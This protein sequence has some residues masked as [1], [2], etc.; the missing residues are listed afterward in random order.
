MRS[1]GAI[2]HYEKEPLVECAEGLGV[3]MCC[4][5]GV[6]SFHF[7]TMG[8]GNTAPEK[9]PPDACSRPSRVFFSQCSYTFSAFI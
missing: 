6:F 4:V 7:A 8:L 1:K 9:R 5:F 3:S 2:S